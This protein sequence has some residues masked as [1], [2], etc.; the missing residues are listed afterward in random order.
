[1]KTIGLLSMIIML[2]FTVSAQGNL[3]FNQVIY[4]KMS[5]VLPTSSS[6]QT[7]QQTLTVPPGKVWK[8]E[9]ASGSAQGSTNY[10][11][12]TTSITLDGVILTFYNGSS[13]TYWE[14][15]FPI[16]LPEG[17]YTLAMVSSTST[18][19]TTITGRLSAI[20]FNVTP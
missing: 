14:T 10:V 12:P 2:A 1:M 3:Q 7:S 5:Y 20:E 15:N 16:W 13:G 17:T 11:S 8:I 19:N 18:V 9:S 4:I 6:F